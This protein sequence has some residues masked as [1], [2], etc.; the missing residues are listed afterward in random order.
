[1]ISVTPIFDQMNLEWKVRNTEPL[2]FGLKITGNTPNPELALSQHLGMLPMFEDF[3]T[4]FPNEMLD[5]TP[6][7]SHVI[8]TEAEPPYLPVMPDPETPAGTQ[9]STDISLLGDLDTL[10]PDEIKNASAQFLSD[11]QIAWILFANHHLQDVCASEG[12]FDDLNW[13][14]MKLRWK[15]ALIKVMNHPSFNG[16]FPHVKDVLPVVVLTRNDEVNEQLNR[17]EAKR[18]EA[19]KKVVRLANRDKNRKS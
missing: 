12:L 1:M 14:E 9:T 19:A 5:F 3:D 15:E 16:S 6:G 17:E 11:N 18:D 4:S 13:Q 10:A 7:A 8:I 2:P